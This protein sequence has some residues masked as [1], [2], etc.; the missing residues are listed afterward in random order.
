[1]IYSCTYT[2]I[3]KHNISRNINAPLVQNSKGLYR[4]GG[5]VVECLPC[6][7]EIGVQSPVGQTKVVKTGSHSSTAKCSATSASVTG[8]RRWPYKWM[9]VSQSFGKLINR[10]CSMAV[11]A[12]TGNGDVSKWVNMQCWN[13]PVVWP[14]PC[15]PK[16]TREKPV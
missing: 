2:R 6:M 8:P 10:H 13:K 12:F 7:W 11:S 16:S 14:S 4:C 9:P 15:N 5:V 1:M 3:K